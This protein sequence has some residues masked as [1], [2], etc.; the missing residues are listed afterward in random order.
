MNLYKA[1]GVN[2]YNKDVNTGEDVSFN[3]VYDRLVSFIGLKELIDC[4][5]QSRKQLKEAYEKDKDFNSI[6]LSNWDRWAG[7]KFDGIKCNRIGSNLQ[8]LLASKDINSYS[9]S[10]LVSLLKHAALKYIGGN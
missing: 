10:Q 1:V 6:P 3:E 5:P 7:F 4:I 2:N 8:L 9:P